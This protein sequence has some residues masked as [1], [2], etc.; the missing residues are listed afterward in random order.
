MGKLSEDLFSKATQL[1]PGG[2]N[3]PVRAFGSVSG[4]PVFI[5]SAHGARMVDVDNV[6]YID[7]MMSWGPMILGHA[8]PF[9]IDAVKKVLARGT[10]YGAPSPLEVEMAEMICEAIPS[11]EMV[12]MV[13][14]G[15]EAVMSAIRLARASTKRDRIVKFD[16]CYHGHSD[17][18]LVRGGSGILTL[19]IP[20]T[21]GVPN[22]VVKDTLVAPFNDREALTNLLSEQGSTVAC[23][24]VE[25]VV[26]N[27][28]VLPPDEGYLQF[29]R[30]ITRQHGILLIFDEVMTGFR[31]AYGGAQELYDIR[32]DLTTL[33]K[34]IGG[35]FPVGAYGGSKEIMRLIAP[36]GP[37]YQAGTLSGNPVA[38]A[39]GLA[40]LKVL[41]NQQTY[42]DLEE[43]S[44]TLQSSF[45]SLAEEY[46]IPLTVNR[47]GSML[48][49]FFTEGPVR[50]H[51]NAAAS[52]TAM[53]KRF[54]Q[55]MFEEGIYLPPSAFE[56]LF[57]S[58]AHS[59]KDLSLTAEAAEK[60][61]K[62]IAKE[63][64][65]GPYR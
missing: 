63:F 8:H 25:P 59:T 22:D 11:V 23:V 54:H 50:N 15:T 9:V 2:V 7:Y 6:T 14:S 62:I 34:I 55:L 21:P 16:G 37:V 30:D 33:G 29:L 52:D 17:S 57:L 46:G 61:M 18:L 40:T 49:A 13:S 53:F 60:S 5:Q 58:L 27:S 45:E 36:S 38:M 12:R 64:E 10:S 51:Q 19:G 1:I 31:V 32:P 41:R 47:V 43:K 39:A 65:L 42:S 20:G 44:A 4:K 28:G 24:I 3:S 56:A 26:G 35:G 48:T